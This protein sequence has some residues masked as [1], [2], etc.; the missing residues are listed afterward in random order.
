MTNN[1]TK[2]RKTHEPH[3]IELPQ[4][5]VIPT[6][7][8]TMEADEGDMLLIDADGGLYPCERETFDE[9]YEP[10]DDESAELQK[11]EELDIDDPTTVP[12]I[13]PKINPIPTKDPYWQFK[14]GEIV[15]DGASIG[16]LDKIEIRC[17]DFTTVDRPES[18]ME[19]HSTGN[20]VDQIPDNS[21]HMK[22]L[23]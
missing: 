13:N 12:T 9:M 14:N 20:T 17:P 5:V 10:V 6:R 7:E 2:Y 4:D 15:I 16:N 22:D 1:W 8:G 18:I 23:E 19:K 3:A 11:F 21:G